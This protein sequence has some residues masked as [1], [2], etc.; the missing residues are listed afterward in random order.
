[1]AIL[2]WIVAGMF[3]GNCGLDRR[4]DVWWQFW[5]GSLPGCCDFWCLAT[6]FG[7]CLERFGYF[8]ASQTLRETSGEALGATLGGELVGLLPGDRHGDPMQ[9]ENC[10]CLERFGNF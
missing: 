6:L 2:A 9:A 7:E 10:E 1:M 3:G 5:P 8:C 4:G